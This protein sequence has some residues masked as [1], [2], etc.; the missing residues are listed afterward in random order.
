MARFVIDLA[1]GLDMIGNEGDRDDADLSY[2][3]ACELS[4]GVGEGRLQPAAGADFALI[5]EAVGIAPSAA[6]AHKAH[7]FLDLSL[8]RVA[9]FDHRHWDAVSAEN[10]FRAPRL[11]ETRKCR[12]HLFYHGVEIHRISI[13]RLDAI[14]GNVVTEMSVP[15]IQA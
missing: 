5:A 6:F 2:P 7:C 1:E 13:E 9:L 11:R 10:D 15:L 14:D 8:V 3:L 12:A 4:K